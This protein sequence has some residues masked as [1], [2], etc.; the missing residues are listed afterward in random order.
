MSREDAYRKAVELYDAAVQTHSARCK[1][2]GRGRWVA[3]TENTE[4]YHRRILA[5]ANYLANGADR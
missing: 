5:I 3:V 1:E 2:S 4:A